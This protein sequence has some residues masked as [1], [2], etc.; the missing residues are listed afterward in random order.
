MNNQTLL[1]EDLGALIA[2]EDPLVIG[3]VVMMDPWRLVVVEEL[4]RDSFIEQSREQRVKGY[5]A[6]MRGAHVATERAERADT[7]PDECRHFY[8]AIAIG[9]MRPQ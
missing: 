9:R 2:T 6:P 5:T 1:P 8:R 3:Q 4:D 7:I